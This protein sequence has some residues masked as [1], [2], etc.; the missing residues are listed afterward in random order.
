MDSLNNGHV[1]NVAARLCKRP[2][3]LVDMVIRMIADH[4]ILQEIVFT[5]RQGTNTY[6][7]LDSSDGPLVQSLAVRPLYCRP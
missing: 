7:E 1:S 3:S 4:R 5:G 6:T 2:T